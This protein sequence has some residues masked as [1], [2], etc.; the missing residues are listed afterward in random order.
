MVIEDTLAYLGYKKAGE[1]E[2][3]KVTV[4]NLIGKT[5]SEAEKLLRSLPLKA[6]TDGVSDIVTEQM[7]PEGA[8]LY[9]G[10][11]VMLYTADQQ[12]ATPE[13]M[14]AVPDVLGMSVV[15]ASRTLRYRGFDLNLIGSGVAVKQSPV[16]GAFAPEGSQVTVT[17]SMP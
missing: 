3:K 6:E 13:V 7:P 15:E 17:F 12:A 4:P 5:V 16:A 1:T 9:A 2:Q 10:G 14:A 8:A 11:Q